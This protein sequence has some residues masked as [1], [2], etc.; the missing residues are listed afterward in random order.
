MLYPKVVLV[1]TAAVLSI[2]QFLV[3]S[4]C[5]HFLFCFF[6]LRNSVIH[7]YPQ[8]RSMY[9]D[10]PPAVDSDEESGSVGEVLHTFAQ[11][12][13]WALMNF[14]FH[15]Q[16]LLPVPPVMS[17]Q[18]LLHQP[19]QKDEE[20]KLSYIQ[21]LRCLLTRILVVHGARSCSGS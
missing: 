2:V 8:V 20:K 16:P 18:A 3:V 10:L 21:L 15:S 11:T 6:I 5:E 14:L 13:A 19:A 1:V 17:Q 12:L 9:S 7:I 4:S